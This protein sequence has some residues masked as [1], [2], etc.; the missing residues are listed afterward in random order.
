MG[1]LHKSGWVPLSRRISSVVGLRGAH[2]SGV[3]LRQAR[4]SAPRREEALHGFTVFRSVI[5]LMIDMH[6]CALDHG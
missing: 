1:V 6:V 3:G 5:R 2:H 4:C